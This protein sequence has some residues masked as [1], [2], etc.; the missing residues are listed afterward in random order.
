MKQ[1]IMYVCEKCG[2]QSHDKE[3]ILKCEAAHFGLTPDEMKEWQALEA[4]A[5]QTGAI[6][7]NI[8]TEQTEKAYDEAI[9]NLMAFEKEHG[10]YY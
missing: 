8:K 1:I 4:K 7:Y 10:L 3:E 9:D 2:K 6:L 5:K